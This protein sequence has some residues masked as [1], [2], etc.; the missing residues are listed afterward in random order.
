M[1]LISF[2]SMF[3]DSSEN[4]E[5]NSTKSL[6]PWL[7]SDE[8]LDVNLDFYENDESSRR[9][10]ACMWLAYAPVWT[11]VLIVCSTVSLTFSIVF[12]GVVQI[13]VRSDSIL[14]ATRINMEGLGTGES[15]KKSRDVAQ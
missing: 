8:S 6:F 14:F 5:G 2:S 15:I 13:F 4:F 12:I 11:K 7:K 10:S 1:S 9:Q 3:Q